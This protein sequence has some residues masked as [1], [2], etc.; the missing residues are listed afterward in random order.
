MA[1][2]NRRDAADAARK[3]RF[4]QLIEGQTDS[5]YR[6]AFTLTRSREDAEDLVQETL[7][8]AWRSLDSFRQG[9]NP[10][11]WLTAIL[12]NS[13]RT[14]YRKKKLEPAVASL[15]TIGLD[16]HEA[17]GEPGAAGGRTL[18]DS[19][20]AQPISDPVLHA[21]KSLPVPYKEALLLVDLEGFTYREAAEI[22]GTLTGT[23]MSRLHRARRRLSRDLAAYVRTESPG[24]RAPVRQRPGP[25]RA[26]E[27]RRLISCGEACRHLHAYVDGILDEADARKIDQHLAACRRCCDRYDFE[28]RQRA[29]LT[30]H[31]LGTPAPRSLLHRLESLIA[32]F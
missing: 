23:V 20:L 32:Q 5:L 11:G 3:Q 24:P 2:A 14:R 1:Q 30:V 31:H 17:A 8:K 22:L 13:S 4:E 16:R 10:R 7:V 29:L 26:I 9:E 15:D 28:R 27:K 19:V 12:V 18:E 25:E 21:I 6:T